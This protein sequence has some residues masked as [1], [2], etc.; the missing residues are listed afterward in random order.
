MG[1]RSK[2]NHNNPLTIAKFI[3]PKP[4][5]QVYKHSDKIILVWHNAYTAAKTL[6]FQSRKLL[7]CC[8]GRS[9]TSCGF[10]WKFLDI[11]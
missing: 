4:I 9:K 3:N 1:Q 7:A 2:Q 11:K 6:S 5:V 10:K 8:R